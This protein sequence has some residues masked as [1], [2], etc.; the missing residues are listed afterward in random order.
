GH[1]LIFGERSQQT[2]FYYQSEIKAWQADGTLAKL[3]LAFSRDQPQRLYVQDK[4]RENAERL[5]NA[6]ADGAAIY[7]CGSAQ[8]M[9][10]AVEQVLLDVLGSDTLTLLIEQ[11]RYRRDVY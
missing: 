4:L 5:Q 11:G 6:I 1:W 9:A 8:G 3:D 2:D 7:V 10:P